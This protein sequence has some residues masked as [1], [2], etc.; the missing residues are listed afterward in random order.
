MLQKK[1]FFVFWKLA[2]ILSSL[3]KVERNFTPTKYSIIPC[4]H[5]KGLSVEK[6]LRFLSNFQSD[7]IKPL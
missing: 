2:N 7:M 3:Q 6:S 4:K 1:T 5:I